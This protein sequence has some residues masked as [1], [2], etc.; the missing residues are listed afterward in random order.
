MSVILITGRW[1]D[2]CTAGPTST[3]TTLAES[4][5]HAVPPDVTTMSFN[6]GSLS[7]LDGVLFQFREYDCIIYAP[8]NENILPVSRFQDIDR[9]TPLAILR[10]DGTG[11]YHAVNKSYEIASGKDPTA[12]LKAVYQY[13]MQKSGG[14]G[15]TV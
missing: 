8:D 4:L 11:A 9:D 14:K 15:A 2:G 12:I 13:L 6:G 10:K 3:G 1:D 7:A 5:R